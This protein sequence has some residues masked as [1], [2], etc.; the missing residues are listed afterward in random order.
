MARVPITTMGFRCEACHHEWIPEDGVDSEPDLCPACHSNLWNQPERKSRMS[1]EDFKS[2]IAKVLNDVGKP[3]TW[4]EV[5]T[6]AALPQAFP[7]NQWVHR[8][9]KD[10]GLIRKRESDGTIHW[11]LSGELLLGQADRTSAKAPNKV[12]A[13]SGGEQSSLE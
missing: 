8:M 10:I 12:K 5:R 11:H 3:L 2:K 13:T 1:Y 4:T 6:I 7:N 9:E